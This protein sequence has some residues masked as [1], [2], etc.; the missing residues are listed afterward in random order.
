MSVRRMGWAVLCGVVLVFGASAQAADPA[1]K[2]GVMRSYDK[3]PL[4]EVTDELSREFRVTITVPAALQDRAVDGAIAAVDL[5]TILRILGEMVGAEIQEKEP[6]WYVLKEA[7]RITYSTPATGED[8]KTVIQAIALSAGANVFVAPDVQGQVFVQA[9]DIPWKQALRDAVRTAGDFVMVEEPGGV[10]RVIRS[11]VLLTQLETEAFPLRY[12]RPPADFVPTSRDLQLAHKRDFKGKANVEF[13]DMPANINDFTLVK[14]LQ[15]VLTPNV[16]RLDYVAD[17]NTLIVR[18]IRPR[19]EEIR[20][21]LAKID[22]QPQQVFVDVNFVTTSDTDF[23]DYGV[24]WGDAGPVASIGGSAAYTRLPFNLG[25]GGLTKY[26]VH[27]IRDYDGEAGST[28][29]N[30]RLTEIDNFAKDRVDSTNPHVF[31]FGMMDFRS[32]NAILRFVKRDVKS[33]VMQAPKIATVDGQRATIFVGQSIRYAQTEASSG[34][35]GTLAF[36]LKEAEGSPVQVGFQ[37]LI[38]PNIVPNEDKI[39]MTVIPNSTTLTG[40]SSTQTGFDTFTNGTQTID[41]PRVST[42]TVITD[43]V[44]D[45][46]QAVVLGGLLTGT[47]SEEVTK[48]PIL[49][50]IPILEFL[51]KNRNRSYSTENLLIFIR[52]EIVKSFKDASADMVRM[53]RRD[54]GAKEA[55]DAKKDAKKGD[56]AN[57]SEKKDEK[58]AEEKGPDAPKK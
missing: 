50:D 43:V 27:K 37:L 16:G 38:I 58:P 1:A 48:L 21:I 56:K 35:S 10:I 28:A 24:D 45:S 29:D 36:V 30:R 42:R 12:L 25:N 53:Q 39:R 13:K 3:R 49:G 8:V 51:F 46:G 22:I 57:G 20:A 6:H 15:N 31:E 17:K 11:E 2:G 14:A 19:I 34:Q 47:D 40:R 18:D 55:K 54:L 44:L 5:P 7:P 26:S 52:P 4:P 33:K 23:L 9:S 41:L 32:V